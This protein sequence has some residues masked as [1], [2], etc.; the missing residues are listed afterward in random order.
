MTK[1]TGALI[2]D[3]THAIYFSIKVN[4]FLNTKCSV[5]AYFREF[6]VSLHTMDSDKYLYF[7]D[8][9]QCS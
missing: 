2:V 8:N 5:F 3:Y 6:S 7:L 4:E 1:L 9:D